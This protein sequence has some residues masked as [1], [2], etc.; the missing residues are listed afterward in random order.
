MTK[1]GILA[2]LL[3]GGVMTAC[4]R[5]DTTDAE[6]ETERV[7]VAA[8]AEQ[9]TAVFVGQPDRESLPGNRIYFTLTQHAWYARGEPL[10]HE[11]RQYQAAGMPIAASVPD[12]ELLGDYQGVEYYARRGD[13]VDA[14][15]VPVFEGYWQ[16][17]R[18]DTTIRPAN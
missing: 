10:L 12:M 9:D 6:T 8:G 15:Y 17:F 1:R 4:G 11:N 14:V 5:D 18:A 13:A 2:A 7:P 3:L 16:P